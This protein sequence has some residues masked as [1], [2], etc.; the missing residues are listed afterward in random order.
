MT[1]EN[2]EE[3]NIPSRQLRSVEKQ[4]E[5]N[6][7]IEA[8]WKTLTDPAELVRWF[9]LEAKVTPGTG[10]SIHL[11]WGLGSEGTNTIDIWEPGKRLRWLEASPFSPKDAAL[12][13]KEYLAVEWTLEARGGKTLLRLVH[14]G[15]VEGADWKNEYYDAVKYGWKFMLTNLRVALERHACVERRVAWPRRQV[16]IAREEAFRR[17]LSPGGL[18]REGVSESLRP[19][20]RYSLHAATGEK[21]SGRVEF[22]VQPRGF[23][24]S[25][26]EWNG[27]LFWLAIEGEPGKYSVQL[28]LSAHGVPQ[29]RVA[30]FGRQWGHVLEGGMF[31]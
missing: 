20:D 21:L 31:Q 27:A 19:G 1:R 23:C 28:W 4:I 17:L 13:S 6:A 30:E 26:E 22:V 14:S 16:S 15:F 10:G 2:P 7:P 12:E 25:V 11:S 29:E 8:V 5:L 3:K 9:P 24:I 18:L